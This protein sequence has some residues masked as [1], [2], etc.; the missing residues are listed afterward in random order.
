MKAEG[1]NGAHGAEDGP[2]RRKGFPIFFTLT[3]I[4]PPFSCRRF[5]AHSATQRQRNLATGMHRGLVPGRRSAG[6]FGSFI[7]AEVFEPK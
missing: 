7:R 1:R 5:V 2:R 4:H 3:L 6:C